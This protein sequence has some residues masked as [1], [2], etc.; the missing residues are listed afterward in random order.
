MQ[1]PIRF[2]YHDIAIYQT[3]EFQTAT[4]FLFLLWCYFIIL[5]YRGGGGFSSIFRYNNNSDSMDYS[6]SN[7][8]ISSRFISLFWM[9]QVIWSALFAL[10]ALRLLEYSGVDVVA[11]GALSSPTLAL[12]FFGVPMLLWIY[13]WLFAVI[14]GLVG[15]CDKFSSLLIQTQLSSSAIG[16][17][18]MVPTIFLLLISSVITSENMLYVVLILFALIL[19]NDILHSFR[20]FIR[21][22]LSILDWFLYLCTVKIIPLSFIWRIL[23][24]HS[25]N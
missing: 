13:Q 7:R 24:T 23:T 1:A 2:T 4:L 15:N 3:P 10:I 19:L 20:L 25:I 9:L 6:I 21:E 18:V 11:M 16:A 8:A 12:L 5:L 14:L 17:S 22:K